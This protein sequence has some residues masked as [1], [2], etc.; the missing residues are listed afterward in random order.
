[1]MILQWPKHITP[2]PRMPNFAAWIEGVDLTK[3]LSAA[4]PAELRQALFEFEV[5]FFKPQVITP[6]QHVALDKV[7]GSLSGGACFNR[8]PTEPQ[9]EVIESD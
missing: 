3:P 2:V 1:M 8:H 7:F 5:I 9:L 6:K 4:V